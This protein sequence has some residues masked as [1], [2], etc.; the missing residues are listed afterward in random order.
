MSRPTRLHMRQRAVRTL[1]EQR[2]ATLAYDC[3]DL[4]ERLGWRVRRFEQRR[5]SAI[6]DL[7]DRLYTHRSRGLGLWYDLKSSD[8][9]LTRGQAAFLLDQLSAGHPAACGDVYVL[10]SLLQCRDR[11]ALM[12][13]ST[14]VTQ[15][16]IAQCARRFRGETLAEAATL[17]PP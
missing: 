13:R 1:R 14:E 8:D 9:R 11:F 6:L 5:R 4:A 2:D 7:S 12:R 16:A 10:A 3:D 15:L 17:P